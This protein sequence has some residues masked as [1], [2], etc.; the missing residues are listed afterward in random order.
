MSTILDHYREIM[1]DP[2]HLMAEVSLMLIVDVL[3]MGVMWPF[4]RRMV[5]RHDREIHGTPAIVEQAAPTPTPKPVYD[6][7]DWDID[8]D[9]N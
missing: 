3:F 1:T 6:D 7:H 4:I 2:A 8:E 9:V 5:R